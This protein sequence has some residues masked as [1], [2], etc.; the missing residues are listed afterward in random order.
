MTTGGDKIKYLGDF[1][2]AS[3][4]PSELDR[5]LRLNEFN[6]VADE[7]NVNVGP[8]Q[9]FFDVVQA[10][11]RR[12]LVDARF[13]KCLTEERPRKR[14][15]IERLEEN[16]RG[17]RETRPRPA[18]RRS[19]R[20]PWKDVPAEPATGPRPSS[21]T[22]TPAKPKSGFL[23]DVFVSHSSVQK[24]L[25][26]AMVQQWRQL[27]LSV[28]FDEDTIQPG[29]DIVTALD[30]ARE[31]SRHTVLI[32]TP[33]SLASGWVNHEIKGVISLDP[34]A[35]HRRLI[36]VLLEAVDSSRILKCA[37][38]TGRAIDGA[39]EIADIHWR[40]GHPPIVARTR[41]GSST[42]TPSESAGCCTPGPGTDPT[43]SRRRAGPRTPCGRPP[44]P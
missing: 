9:Y 18:G 42:P 40:I 21:V 7:V 28:F 11:D 22:P 30:R 26:R 36:P 2:R 20:G 38:E 24:P 15:E 17:E 37:P 35:S 27:G 13:F 31:K 44:P 4:R 32:I 6:E 23:W 8:N 25:V 34:D 43:A 12:G 29:E 5:F 1:L 41:L 10:L 16:W 3:F 39:I 19:R 33:E 14:V